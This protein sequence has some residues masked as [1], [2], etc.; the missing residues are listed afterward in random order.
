MKLKVMRAMEVIMWPCL[1]PHLCASPIHCL[2]QRTMNALIFHHTVGVTQ[3]IFNE[4][5]CISFSTLDR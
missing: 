4:Q 1:C 5:M 3:Y 2:L